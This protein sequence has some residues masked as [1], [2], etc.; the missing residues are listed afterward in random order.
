MQRGEGRLSFPA[1]TTALLRRESLPQSPRSLT[2]QAPG[3]IR[4]RPGP[5]EPCGPGRLS[6][7][8]ESQ[9][10]SRHG[11]PWPHRGWEQGAPAEG[12][13]PSAPGRRCE[14][15][16]MGVA[17]GAPTAGKGP[18]RAGTERAAG[19]KRCL[20]PGGPGQSTTGASNRGFTTGEIR[21]VGSDLARAAGGRGGSPGRMFSS[22]PA[23]GFLMG[24]SYIEL[25]E[26][27]KYLRGEVSLE[28]RCVCSF[29]S[30]KVTGG[31]Q[32]GHSGQHSSHPP[33]KCTSVA[34]RPSPGGSVP[35]GRGRPRRLPGGSRRPG[36]VAGGLAVGAA[37]AAPPRGTGSSSAVEIRQGGRLPAPTM[38]LFS[39]LPEAGH[40]WR[41]TP[42]LVR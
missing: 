36:G 10:V 9:D 23:R 24:K 13:A 26:A 12:C 2:S 18:T 22:R 5:P 31:G 42:G 14:A 4:S 25:K 37:R 35:A 34:A 21:A 7:R 3:R 29:K 33:C 17:A 28:E 11:A 39:R 27:N 1:P 8:H 41:I 16:V 20:Q 15:P 30:R 19:R 40:L 6:P 38:L 32:R